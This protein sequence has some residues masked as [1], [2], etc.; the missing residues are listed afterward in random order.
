MLQSLRSQWGKDTTFP[1]SSLTSCWLCLMFLIPSFPEAQISRT[2][3]SDGIL[4]SCRTALRNHLFAFSCMWPKDCN[5]TRSNFS[6]ALWG[7][8]ILE[9]SLPKTSRYWPEM[10]QSRMYRHRWNFFSK[11]QNLS[12][13]VF[14]LPERNVASHINSSRPCHLGTRFKN[15]CVFSNQLQS[16]VWREEGLQSFFLSTLHH[17]QQQNMAT[18]CSCLSSCWFHMLT[19]VLIQI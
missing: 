14:L 15:W 8:H 1:P 17:F 3:I 12:M 16:M 5:W 6:R 4:F 9:N 2:A 18:E 11:I 13:L 7:I 10:P 19:Y